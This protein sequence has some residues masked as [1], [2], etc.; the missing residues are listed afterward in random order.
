MQLARQT[1][2]LF[3]ITVFTGYFAELPRGINRRVLENNA[4]FCNMCII[5]IRKNSALAL[6]NPGFCYPAANSI[7]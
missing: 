7:L 5:L 1:A 2:I 6:E 4:L 3:L